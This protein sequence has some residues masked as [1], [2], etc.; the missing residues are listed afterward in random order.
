MSFLRS[1]NISFDFLTIIFTKLSSCHWTKRHPIPNIEQW[2]SPLLSKKPTVAVTLA[3]F[4]MS[5]NGFRYL[6]SFECKRGNRTEAWGVLVFVFVYWTDEMVECSFYMWNCS[7]STTPHCLRLS[8][9]MKSQLSYHR[10]KK[11]NY[12]SG[13]FFMGGGALSLWFITNG[14]NFIELLKHRK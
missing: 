13:V 3:Y 14:P 1:I 8:F 12:K 6:H 11:P 9:C 7:S 4:T 5:C 10:I 2:Q